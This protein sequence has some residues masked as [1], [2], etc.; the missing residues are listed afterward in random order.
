MALDKVNQI[1]YFGC[2]EILSLFFLD[3]IYISYCCFRSIIF[4]PII[5]LEYYFI[6]Y[7]THIM[8]RVQIDV[9]KFVLKTFITFINSS[10]NLNLLLCFVL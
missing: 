3:I 6:S 9:L 7:Y 1:P 10:I 2:F 8:S 4:F 5:V